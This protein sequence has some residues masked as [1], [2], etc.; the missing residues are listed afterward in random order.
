MSLF[1][2]RKGR[3]ATVAPTFNAVDLGGGEVDVT[4]FGDVISDTPRDWDGK[5]VEGQYISCEDVVARLSAIDGASH[6]TV[7]L[8]SCGGDLFAGVAIHNALKKTGAKVTVR[9][10]GIAASSASVIACAGDEVVVMPGSIFMVH[11]PALCLFGFY[12]STDLDALKSDLDAGF[13]S[14]CNIYEEKTGADRASIE[15]MVRAETWMVGQEAV[16]AGFADTLDTGSPSPEVEEGEDG[17]ELI[18]YGNRHDMSA[19]RSVPKLA[20]LAPRADNKETP[21]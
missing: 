7:H 13:R 16:D 2:L 15:E 3:A 19:C 18:T 10:E 1:N 21:G 20:A 11:Q 12:N 4:L 14:V 5:P 17:G 9:V 6:V 8:N